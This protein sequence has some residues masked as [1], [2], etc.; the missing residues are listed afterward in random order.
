MHF[1]DTVQFCLTEGQLLP[2]KA[3]TSVL[4]YRLFV[5]CKTRTETC[6]LFIWNSCCKHRSGQI[7][8]RASP[9]RLVLAKWH[10]VREFLFGRSVI[11]PSFDTHLLLNNTRNRK[12]KRN[13]KQEMSFSNIE[14][15]LDRR[16]TLKLRPSLFWGVT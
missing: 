3:P 16:S 11:P 2:Y 6:I 1:S 10:Y 7:R 9:C 4:C 14:G 13:F 5:Y 12:D 8:L 15:A